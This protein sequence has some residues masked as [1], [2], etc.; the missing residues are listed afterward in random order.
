MRQLLTLTE[1]AAVLQIPARSLYSQRSRGEEPG[2]LGVRI[3]RH[4]RFDPAVLE[5]WLARQRQGQS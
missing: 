1:V 3:G 5:G 2:S 4:V